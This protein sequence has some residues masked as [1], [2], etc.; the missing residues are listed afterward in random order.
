MF[1]IGE[2]LFRGTSLN[3]ELLQGPDLTSSLFGVF[4][5]FREEPVAVMTDIQAMFHQVRVP[6]PMRFLW[7]PTGDVGKPPVEHRMLVHL[8]GAVSS[9]SCANFVLRQTARDNKSTFHPK[10]IRT[11]ENNF[12]VDDCLKSLSS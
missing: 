6:N 3:S 4:T 5:R 12:N 11:I 9:S 1:S 10:V 2:Q 8:F 7:W